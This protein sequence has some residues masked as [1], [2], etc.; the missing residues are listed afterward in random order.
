MSEVDEIFRDQEVDTM[1]PTVMIFKNSDDLAAHAADLV[2]QV[3][4]KAIAARG[5]AMLALAG[6]STPKKTYSLL[7]EP[8]R[9]SKIDWA[10][11]YLF[12]GDERFV[13][14]DDRSSNFAMVQKALL[15]P[16]SV[17]VGHV[18][19]IPTQLETAAAAASEYA[20]T[21][22]T[23][24]GIGNNGDPPRFDLVLL[25]LGDDGHTASLFSGSESLSAAHWVV[26]SPPGTLPPPIERI[27]MTFPVLNAAREIMFLVAGQNKAEVV[28]DVLE[29]Q[30][31]CDE[32]PA[33]GV[34]PVDGTLTWLLDEAAG[35]HLTRNWLRRV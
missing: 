29:G 33:V 9:G 4:Q 32:L 5:R 28:H 19:P 8:E 13:P 24:F 16:A 20:A 35:S 22:A 23:A 17:P 27:T 10:K 14:L 21:L 2:V 31:S 12:F 3:T 25:G 34:S 1:S 11:T 6:G 30:P 26:A 7:A 18:F 15:E